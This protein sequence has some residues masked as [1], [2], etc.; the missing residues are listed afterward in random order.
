MVCSDSYRSG[1]NFGSKRRTDRN[2]FVWSAP[3]I[4]HPL[5]RFPL[6]ITQVKQTTWVI[7]HHRNDFMDQIMLLAM[8]RRPP[9]DFN[10]QSD[11]SRE[12]S[13]EDTQL[14]STKN[15][16]GIVALQQVID[17]R[18]RWLGARSALQTNYSAMICG[19]G[20]WGRFICTWMDL[21]RL[22]SRCSLVQPGMMSLASD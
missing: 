21:Y 5:T 8:R 7:T 20:H 16:Y 19:R 14:G 10:S 4:F 9:R 12:R 18:L 2:L 1:Y 6:P 3:H 15:S 22:L 17:D 11:I 13:I